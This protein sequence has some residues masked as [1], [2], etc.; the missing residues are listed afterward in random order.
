MWIVTEVID[1][2]D[3]QSDG[4]TVIRSITMTLTLDGPPIWFP[5]PG[6]RVKVVID[7]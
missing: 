5:E 6:D 4:V 1:Q 3:W 2:E 7:A